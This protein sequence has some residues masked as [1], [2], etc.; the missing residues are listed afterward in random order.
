MTAEQIADLKEE[1]SI[2][3]NSQ[4]LNIVDEYVRSAEDDC[5][6]EGIYDFLIEKLNLRNSWKIRGLA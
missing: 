4:K 2:Y 3:S 1:W 6:F 5:I